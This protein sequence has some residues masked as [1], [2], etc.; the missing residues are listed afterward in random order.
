[1]T[2]VCISPFLLWGWASYQFL[3]KSDLVGSQFSEL[4]YWE[5]G[6]EFFKGGC[7]FYMKNKLKSEVFNEKKV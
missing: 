1:M 5:R 7:S 6:G 3:K 4:G 2:T